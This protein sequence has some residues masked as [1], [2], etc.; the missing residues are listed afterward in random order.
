M[1]NGKRHLTDG[2]ELPNHDKIRTP[3]ENETYKFLGILETDTIKQGEMKDKIWKEYPGRT[4]KLFETKLYSRNLIK[5]INT[6]ALL[7]VWYSGPFLKWTRDELKQNESKKKK[8]NDP[9]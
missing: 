4:R 7:L 6:W 8:T 5:R 1:K 3:R 9:A 2:M